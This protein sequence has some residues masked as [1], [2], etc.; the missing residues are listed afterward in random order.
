VIIKHRR[1]P[2]LRGL[3]PLVFVL[4]TGGL[5]AAAPRSRMARRLLTAEGLAYGSLAAFFAVRGVHRRRESWTLL[6]GVLAAFPAFHLGQG[7]G[8]LVGLM[9]ALRRE[10][11]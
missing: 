5:L 7:S 3:V 2:T 6:P 4:G 10:Q 11:P 8:Q 9:L 1:I